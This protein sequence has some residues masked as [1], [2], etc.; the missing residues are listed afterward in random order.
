MWRFVQLAGLSLVVD[1]FGGDESQESRESIFLSFSRAKLAVDNLLHALLVV[2]KVPSKYHVV[3]GVAL[4]K[5]RGTT[6]KIYFSRFSRLTCSYR[7]KDRPENLP[8]T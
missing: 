3:S 7:K 6:N 4:D 2:D 1:N 8:A 5:S